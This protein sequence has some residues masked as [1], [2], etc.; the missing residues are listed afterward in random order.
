MNKYASGRAQCVCVIFITHTPRRPLWRLII[1]RACR[2]FWPILP[3]YRAQHTHMRT[4]TQTRRGARNLR[5]AFIMHC[6][7]CGA[8]PELCIRSVG[9]GSAG[10]IKGCILVY[11]SQLT[12]A[13]SLHASIGASMTSSTDSTRPSG[14][15]PI[16]S[17]N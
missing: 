15:N 12:C 10:G 9:R 3:V 7:L 1:T 13:A 14:T 2:T 8:L 17:L 11:K 6:I 16:P 5:F 4:H